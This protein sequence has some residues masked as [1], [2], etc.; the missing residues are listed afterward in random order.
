M[1]TCS[2]TNAD[3]GVP[4]NLVTYTGDGAHPNECI[5]KCIFW[6]N[7]AGK[8]S[9]CN[10][11]NEINKLTVPYD[12]GGDIMYNSDTFEPLNVRIF[13]PSL[14][15][16]DGAQ[17]EAELILEH[18][19]KSSSMAGL[20]VCI[21]ISTNAPRTNASVILETIIDNAPRLE[22][23][24]ASVSI[25]NFNL[26]NIIPSAP[27]YTYSGPLPYDGCMPDSVYQYIAFHPTKD[28]ALNIDLPHLEKLSDLIAY[29]NVAAVEP[30][31][32]TP[33]FF[34]PKGTTQNGFNGEDQIYIQCQPAGESEETK[35]YKEP[36]SPFKKSGKDNEVIKIIVFIILGAAFIVGSYLLMNYLTKFIRWTPPT[37][38]PKALVA[39]K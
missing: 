2:D 18:T 29:S 21:P 5:N 19:S 34:N 28:G 27:Y 30:S 11:A 9:S 31:E 33:V 23:E 7:Y 15:T 37:V 32:S 1:T 12:G 14:H 10:I 38:K 35:V 24:R 20:L 13:S 17:A 3:L 8:P 25:N 36:S 26:N 39:S 16:Y 22:N 4:Q 6:Y